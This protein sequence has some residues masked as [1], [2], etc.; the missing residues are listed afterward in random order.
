MY[1][2]YLRTRD[3]LQRIAKGLGIDPD[4]ETHVLATKIEEEV[5][6]LVDSVSRTAGIIADAIQSQAEKTDFIR[7]SLCGL[8]ESPLCIRDGRLICEDCDDSLSQQR[9][10]H[11][12]R[13]T[14]EGTGVAPGVLVACGH[15]GGTGRES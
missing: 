3:T 4:Q 12:C 13:G 8:D 11:A 15:C 9:P 10:C 6:T 7:C 5:K 1:L 2:Q 14:G